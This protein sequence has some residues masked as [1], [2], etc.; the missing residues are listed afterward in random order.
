M[1][2]LIHVLLQLLLAFLLYWPYISESNYCSNYTNTD[3]VII[4]K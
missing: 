2:G 4:S 3:V 1:N